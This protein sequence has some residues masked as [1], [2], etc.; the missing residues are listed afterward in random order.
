MNTGKMEEPDDFAFLSDDDA[1][2]R[3]TGTNVA[4]ARGAAGR[5]ELEEV[6]AELV[7]A[8]HAAPEEI[9]AFADLAQRIEVVRS[10][11]NPLLE[12]ARPLLRMLADMPATLEPAEAVWNLKAMLVRELHTFQMIC[13]KALQPW[14]HMAAVRYCLCTAL[15][16]AANRTRWGGGGVW[17]TSSLLISFEGENDGGEKFFLLIGRMATDP[18]TY[19]DVL[20]VLYRILGLGFEGRYSVIE[21]GRRHLEQIRQRLATLIG[22]AGDAVPVELS[23]HWQGAGPGKVRALYIVPVWSVALVLAVAVFGVFAWYK[24]H[25]LEASR[26]LEA[27]ILDLGRQQLGIAPE[28]L[29]LPTLLKE[30]ISDGLVTVDESGER[31]LV[32]FR[33]DSMFLSGKAEV[34]ESMLPVLEKVAKEVSRAG[35]YVTVVGHTDN[36]A[37]RTREFPDN[38]ALSEKRAQFVAR[39][40]QSYG[41]PANR[42]EAIGLG[43]T[44]PVASNA[45][46]EDRSRNRR[47]EVVVTQ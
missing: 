10:A 18:Q 27:R 46:S 17:A 40:L 29:R 24:Y 21:D 34:Q 44:Q 3:G 15:D 14:T 13:D 47:V 19:L 37:I 4:D 23:P 32:V 31:S 41:T 26:T 39:V 1:L 28:R 6:A 30:E 2:D 5:S 35:G 12:A 45:T 11:S 43:D 9:P 42:I 16:E 33:G 38:K 7:S 22:G 8:H 25:L 20:E 36:L